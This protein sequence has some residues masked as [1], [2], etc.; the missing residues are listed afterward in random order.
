MRRLAALLLAS[1]AFAIA[2]LPAPPAQ[3]QEPSTA[4]LVLLSQTRWNSP[5]QPKLVIDVRAYN[6]SN[7]PLGQLSLGATLFGPVFSRTEYESSLLI[8]PSTG[9]LAGQTFPLEETLNPGTSQVFRIELDLSTLRGLSTTQSLIYPLKIDLRSEFTPL[10]SIR[11]PVVFLV[12]KPLVPLNL[13]WTFV[14]SSPVDFGPDGVFQ[15]TTLEHEI[16]PNGRLAREIRALAGLVAQPRP[17]PVDVVVSPMLLVQLNRMRD[18]YSVLD[19]GQVRTVPSGRAGA[20]AAAEV[21]TELKR[22][23]ASSAVQLLALPFSEPSLP[24]LVAGGLAG[25]L[26]AQL[27]LGAQTV[28]TVLQRTPDRTVLRPPDSALDQTSLDELPAQGV[29]LLLLDSSAVPLPEQAKGFASPP[30]VFLPTDGSPVVALISDQNVETLLSSSL[31]ADG[32]VLAAQAVLGELAAIWLQAPSDT[33]GISLTF[34]ETIQTAP[35][36]SFRQLVL[37]IA[38]APWLNTRT[39]TAL[40]V[41]FPPTAEGRIASAGW[42]EF[43]SGYSDRLKQ[44]RRQ[45]EIYRSMLVGESRAADRLDSQ[46][47]LAEAGRFVHD[48]AGGEAF[49]ASVRDSVGVALDAVGPDRGQTRTITVTPG[50]ARGIPVR[51]TNGNEE[52]LRVTVQLLSP[53]KTGPPT[54]VVLPANQTQTVSFDVELKTTGRFPVEV[55]VLS[56]SGRLIGQTTL[57]VRSTELNGIALV[58]TIGAALLGLLVWARR[59]LPR[60]TS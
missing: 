48:P 19:G 18:G 23:A 16:A 3:A 5:R 4:R 34:P 13:A 60:R 25:D 2:P 38:D 7:T 10:A 6:E 31:A 52:P 28:Q 15:S 17:V 12:R 53:L 24:A 47:L 37:G 55:R 22:I 32:G 56:P 21:L 29:E 33:R 36:T 46:L 40:A 8:D 45:V 27:E 30:A 26:K 44:A 35:G 51:I 1:L 49:I 42:E 39:A 58:I 20:A 41:T 9:V 54:S 57:T 43:P 50:S 59:F 14:L 11:T